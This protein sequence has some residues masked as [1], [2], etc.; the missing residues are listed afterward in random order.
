MERYKEWYDMRWYL[1]GKITGDENYRLKFEN[2]EKFLKRKGY[3][4]ILNPVRGEKDG[5][6]WSYYMKRD[7]KKLLKCDGIMLLEDFQKSK[8]AKLEKIIA[9]NLGYKVRM[10]LDNGNIVQ[11]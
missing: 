6:E 3:R 11:R 4:K 1:S 9:E 8:G 5:K 10:L 2:A 7:I